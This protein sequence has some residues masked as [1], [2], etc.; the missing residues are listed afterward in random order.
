MIFPEGPTR[1]I[2]CFLKNLE[3]F[4][5]CNEKILSLNNLIYQNLKCNNQNIQQSAL[6][7]I[8]NTGGYRNVFRGMTPKLLI[9]HLL[10]DATIFG[11]LTYGQAYSSVENFLK[12]WLKIENIDTTQENLDF[13]L[14][15]LMDF[16][17]FWYTQDQHCWESFFLN[18]KKE[19]F[20]IFF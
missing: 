13:N 1:T 4:E 2:Y 3:C 10:N 11:P 12:M 19:K 16:V 7:E 9:E 14:Y 15:V 5:R 18:T 20:F 17:S 6:G 8:R